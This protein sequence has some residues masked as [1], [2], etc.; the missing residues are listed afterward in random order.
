MKQVAPFNLDE[1][2]SVELKVEASRIGEIHGSWT[3][4]LG[5]GN[6]GQFTRKVSSTIRPKR[7]EV[8][9]QVISLLSQDDAHTGLT[10]AEIARRLGRTKGDGTVRRAMDALVKEKQIR[11][12]GDRYLLLPLPLAT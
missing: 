6:Y 8:G 3:I 2:G 1:K 9:E 10:G 5:D 4:E 11:R 7:S 12:E